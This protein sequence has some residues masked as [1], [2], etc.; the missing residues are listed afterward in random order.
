MAD[1]GDA[2]DRRLEV[3][4][5]FE[6]HPLRDIGVMLCRFSD[7]RCDFTYA[8]TKKSQ[9]CCSRQKVSVLIF[10]VMIL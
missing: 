1:T 9:R 2:R 3:V 5:K 6:E 8:E 4:N 7:S 10:N